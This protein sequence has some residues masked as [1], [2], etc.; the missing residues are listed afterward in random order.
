M[1]REIFGARIAFTQTSVVIDS[2]LARRP[3]LGTDP[4]ARP[5]MT[6]EMKL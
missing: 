4:F 3:A 5:G 6:L 1:L 2:G